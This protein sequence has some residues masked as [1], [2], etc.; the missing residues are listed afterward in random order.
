[1]VPRQKPAARRPAAVANEGEKDG[2]APEPAERITEAG[3]GG[4][5]KARHRRAR[6]RAQAMAQEQAEPAA[7]PGRQRQPAQHGEV[8]RALAHEFADDGRHG[9]AA[10]RLFHRPGAV[11]LAG[12]AQADHV[13]H[14]QAEA[15]EPRSVE[16][17]AFALGGLRLDPQ[18]VAAVLPHRADEQREG[19]GGAGTEV[20][21]RGRCNLVQNA[22][23]EP[24][25]ECLVKRWNAEGE[26]PT[27]GA[28]RTSRR[29]CPPGIP[30]P[31][32]ILDR[33]CNAGVRG[34]YAPGTSAP[35]RATGA[36]RALR[37]PRT[38]RVITLDFT[39]P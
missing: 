31:P 5:R 19:E 15:I 20:E 8:E 36:L 18:G 38:S 9:P 16:A 21:G 28:A 7:L 24:A 23:R 34:A 1:M 12:D 33:R 13:R 2:R 26:R 25:A 4:D 6:P 35:P 11:A 30:R 3:S 17:A 27:L 37:T 29:G 32:C 14:R 39:L 10:Q 22:A